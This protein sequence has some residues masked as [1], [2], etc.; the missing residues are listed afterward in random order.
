MENRLKCSKTHGTLKDEDFDWAPNPNL[1]N[2]RVTIL[3]ESG[4]RPPLLPM[5]PKSNHEQYVDT[6]TRRY[7]ESYSTFHEEL[8]D[9][10]LGS[11]NGRHYFC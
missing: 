4:P 10:Y 1:A 2:L 11:H 9:G 7:I 5:E 3:I 8:G 6:G